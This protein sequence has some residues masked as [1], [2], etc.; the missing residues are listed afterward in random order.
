MATHNSFSGSA[1]SKNIAE[2]SAAQ[3]KGKVFSVTILNAPV[4][5]FF[6]ILFG[7]VLF[8]LV[9]SA[10]A[11]NENP[12]SVRAWTSEDGLPENKV[13]GV[14]QTRDG[15]LWVATQGGLVRF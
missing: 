13:V 10:M 4:K 11:E 12:Y 15:S 1:C 8:R 14:A 3:L 7:A 9:S 6:S 5:S 2:K